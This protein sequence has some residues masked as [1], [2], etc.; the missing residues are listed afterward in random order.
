MINLIVGRPRSGKTYESTRYHILPAVL[1]DKRRVVTNVTINKEYIE[2]VHGREYSDLITIIEGCFDSYGQTRPFSSEEDFLKFD[3]WKNKKGQGVLFV[4]DEAHLSIGRN[5]R[6]A[7]LEYLSMHGHYGHD[8]LLLTQNARKLNKDLKDMVEI[9]WRTVKQSAFGKDDMYFRKTHHGVE[10]IRESV[11]T[12]ERYYDPQYFNYY[13]SHTQSTGSV[14]EAVAHDVKGKI[15]P[16]SKWSMRIAIIGIA[17]TLFS[18]YQ[19]VGEIK[20]TGENEQ[21]KS[22]DVNQ[23]PNES[24]NTTSPKTKLEKFQQENDIDVA[25][26]RVTAEI[27]RKEDV[28]KNQAEETKKRDRSMQYHPYHKVLLHVEG[29]YQDSVTKSFNV[30]FSASVNGQKVFNLQLSD[31]FLA[32]YSVI[33]LSDCLVEISYYEYLD[34][35]TCDV[36]QIMVSSLSTG[37]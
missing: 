21:P 29:Q 3:D 18:V 16:T 23:T 9:V 37:Q 22:I 17:I 8:I 31:L 19:A 34:Y 35:L 1:E 12:E 4:I 13:K 2:K 5:A 26:S 25:G 33:V 14:L 32:G 28:S 36:P 15:N 10:N 20:S 6:P 30:Y 7:V 11:H 27:S 24:N